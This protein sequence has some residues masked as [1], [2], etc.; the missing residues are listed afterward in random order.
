[1]A[2][3]AKFERQFYPEDGGYESYQLFDYLHCGCWWLAPWM[4]ELGQLIYPHP[5]WEFKRGDQ[6][7]IAYGKGD[8]GRI[9]VVFDIMHFEQ[10]ANELMDID[11]D[12]ILV[13]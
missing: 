1:M 11:G 4:K 13:D 6:L 10:P 2:R 9:E 5:T 7:G 8:D 3:Y 12:E